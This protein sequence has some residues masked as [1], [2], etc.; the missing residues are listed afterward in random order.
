MINGAQFYLTGL[1]APNPWA[2][3]SRAD[4][5]Q[6]TPGPVGRAGPGGSYQLTRAVVSQPC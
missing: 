5:Q 6:K 1:I 4:C 3:M 2:N